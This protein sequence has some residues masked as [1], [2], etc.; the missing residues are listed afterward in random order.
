MAT[1]YQADDN[2]KKWEAIEARKNAYLESA[3]RAA[4]QMGQMNALS[5]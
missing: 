4:Q 3:Q 1:Y 2:E 5:Q